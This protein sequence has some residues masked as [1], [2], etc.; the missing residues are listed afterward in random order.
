M[1]VIGQQIAQGIVPGSEAGGNMEM[2]R[3]R[4]RTGLL[5]IDGKGYPSYKRIKGRYR[6]EEFELS[7]DYVQ[8]DPFASPSRL[9]VRVPVDMAGFP[10]HCF[11]SRI[12]RIAFRDFIARQFA[13]LC[14]D[15]RERQGS[16]KSGLLSMDV[17]GQEI[18]E[19]SS[20]VIED[21]FIEARFV[22]GLPANGRRIR[23]RQAE[24]MLCE[25]IPGL[26]RRT[27][28]FDSINDAEL[29][30]HLDVCE[31]AAALREALDAKGLIAFIADGSVLP[32]CSGIDDRPL[33]T[34]AV[35]F[36]SPDSMRV[37]IPTPHA[38]EISGMGIRKGVTLVVGGGYHGKSTLLNALEKGVYNHVPGDGREKA[39][40]TRT[41]VKIRA[42]DGRSVQGVNITPFINNLP[43]ERRPGCFHTQNASGSTSQAAN[44]MEAVEVKADALFLDEDTC[45]TNLMIR[46]ARMQNLVE[47]SGEPITPFL[48]RVGSLYNDA[49]ISTIIVLGG[50]GDYFE[51]ADQVIRMDNFRPFDV[52][53]KAKEIA[54]RFP[55]L[56]KEETL[57]HWPDLGVR[58]EPDPRSI[59]PRK[60]KKSVS[61]KTRST[62][63]VIFGAHEIDMSQVSQ[64]VDE[65]QLRAIGRAMDMIRRK[66][67]GGASFFEAIESICAEVRENG[68]DVLDD[69]RTGDYV[70]FRPYELAAALNRL[71]T[72]IV[73]GSN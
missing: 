26:A 12:R 34:G 22:A 41:S 49:G 17:P 59:D 9:R 37:T 20:V 50:S 35:E 55:S 61:I 23:G 63:A 45:A 5:S 10:E 60:G 64:I 3:D 72:L 40:S 31:D 67:A 24:V 54:S 11:S 14:C 18:M 42:E 13:A 4:L 38:G 68:L 6:F 53:G 46:D 69:R 27:M 39:V 29:K 28:F 8:G 58:R 32:R 70:E 43:G 36:Q 16:G 7:I 33:D 25:K 19:R 1:M 62:R 71:R 66:L 65:G 2:D 57:E 56:R 51:V 30:K 52:T 21:S 44:I 47:K 48:D 73:P 15:L